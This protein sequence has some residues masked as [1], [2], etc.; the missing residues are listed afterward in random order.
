M[1]TLS[2]VSLP[3]T[4]FE[5]NLS[6]VPTWLS[7]A[8]Q[9]LI[10]WSLAS[11]FQRDFLM[12]APRFLGAV[13]LTVVIAMVLSASFAALLAWSMPAHLATM[14]LAMAPGGI[15]EM[16]ITAKALQLG[17]PLVTAF[18]V[19]RMVLL[20]SVT[21]VIYQWANDWHAA[22]RNRMLEQRKRVEDEEERVE[23]DERE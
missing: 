14:I 1:W 9:L 8:G 4:A 17:V 19:A 12:R 3:L 22:R 20:V 21:G 13:T 23:R 7:N 10:G 15:A 18:H 2:C 6:S 11:R 16:A 5:V